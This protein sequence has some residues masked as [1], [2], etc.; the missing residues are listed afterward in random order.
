MEEIIDGGTADYRTRL[1]RSDAQIPLTAEC[2]EKEIVS[3]RFF[4]MR[5]RFY[6]VH[7]DED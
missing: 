6:V 5:K 1:D 2:R 4:Y 7:S 3:Q